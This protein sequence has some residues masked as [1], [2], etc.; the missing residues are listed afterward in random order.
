MW[1]LYQQNTLSSNSSPDHSRSRSSTETIISPIARARN[2]FQPIPMKPQKLLKTPSGDDS[3]ISSAPNT[4]K[5]LKDEL[6]QLGRLDGLISNPSSKL[7]KVRVPDSKK[8]AAI[9]L[10]TNI[11]ELQRHLLTITVQ[12]QVSSVPWLGFLSWR[13]IWN[14]IKTKSVA[15]RYKKLHKSDKLE[16][17]FAQECDARCSAMALRKMKNSNLEVKIKSTRFCELCF[18][19]IG[20]AYRFSN[21]NIA[22]FCFERSRAFLVITRKKPAAQHFLIISWRSI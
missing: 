1:L 8:I 16:W 7:N 19:V 17:L 3:A 4:S 21:F 10:E 11:V 9:L 5:Q 12:N 18:C 22:L 15:Q 14:W 6:N 2:T 20:T 13:E